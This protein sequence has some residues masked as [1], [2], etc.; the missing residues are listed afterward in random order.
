MSGL[1]FRWP[2]KQFC[3]KHTF[4]Q[5]LSSLPTCLYI[6]IYIYVYVTYTYVICYVIYMLRMLTSSLV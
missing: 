5:D 3:V 6:Y 2:T 1:P 4:I